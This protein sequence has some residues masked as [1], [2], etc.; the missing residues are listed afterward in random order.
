MLKQDGEVSMKDQF[1]KV[2]NEE[3]NL[4]KQMRELDDM[5]CRN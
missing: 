5:K 2:T 4:N 3:G 1:L